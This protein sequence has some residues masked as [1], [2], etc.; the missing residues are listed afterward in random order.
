MIEKERYGDKFQEH[1]LDQYKIYVELADRVTERR[2]KANQ[3]YSSLFSISIP[4]IIAGITKEIISNVVSLVM[5]AFGVLLCVGWYYNINSYKQ[6]NSGKFKVIH[7]ME[8]HLPF[9]CFK[10]EWN[11]L[12]HGNDASKYLKLTKI[13]QYIP[14]VFLTLFLMLMSYS[15]IN[16][17]FLI[18]APIIRTLPI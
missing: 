7:E 4:L 5:S 6:L 10:R 14:L 12:K 16:G 18:L 8:E 1:L 13:E 9:D 15:I 3:F 11:H 17:L 2:H